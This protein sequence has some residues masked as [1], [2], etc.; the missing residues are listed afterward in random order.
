MRVIPNR[1]R[2]ETTDNS[3][4]LHVFD[5]DVPIVDR[6]VDHV[7]IMSSTKSK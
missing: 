2:A 4:N 1:R 3:D 5:I 6:D 7:V